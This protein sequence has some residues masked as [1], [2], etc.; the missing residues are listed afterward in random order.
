MHGGASAARN[1]CIRRAQYAGSDRRALRLLAG[2]VRHADMTDMT[3][4]TTDTPDETGPIADVRTIGSSESV[5]RTSTTVSVRSS[6]P[7]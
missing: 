5:V 2:V 1:T 6:L 4:T 7:G 3:D